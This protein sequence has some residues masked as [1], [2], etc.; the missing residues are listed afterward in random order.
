MK[1]EQGQTRHN[2]IHG[3]ATGALV[4]HLALSAIAFLLAVLN[5]PDAAAQQNPKNV[6][7]LSSGRG[8]V[9]I[10][11]MESSLRARFSG[12]VNFS[13]V[14]LE[15]PRFEQ[16]TYEDNL[17]E[18][19]RTGYAAEKPDLIV[20]VMTV[21]IEFAARYRDRM[22]PGVPVVFMS[23]STPLPA[24][25][26]PGITGVFSTS[27]ISETIDLALRLQ[28]DTQDIAV[29]TEIAGADKDWLTE[30]QSELLHH[31]DRVKEIDIV[32]PASPQ[33][34]QKVAELPPHTVLLFQ[35]YPHNPRLIAV[36]L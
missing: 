20:A 3:F 30:E 28:P 33:T 9:S 25:M 11:Q 13:V 29:V 27:G 22:F 34:I 23:V 12:P 4:L 24:K 14:D 32:G 18:A 17:A 8:R 1:G 26:W 36:F 19:L 6:M 2:T 10:N 31:R 16:K 7:I 35:L 5:I 15:N 21:S